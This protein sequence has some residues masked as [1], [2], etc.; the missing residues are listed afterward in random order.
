LNVAIYPYV[1]LFSQIGTLR[2]LK[3]IVEIENGEWKK[4]GTYEKIILPR[5]FIPFKNAAI[6]GQVY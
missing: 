2:N 5:D 3:K 4:C 6:S 1:R